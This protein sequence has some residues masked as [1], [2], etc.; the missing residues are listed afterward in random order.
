MI[1]MD[2]GHGLVHITI[3]NHDLFEFFDLRAWKKIQKYP[4]SRALKNTWRYSEF[5]EII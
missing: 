1:I 3:V 2:S 4:K 5:L